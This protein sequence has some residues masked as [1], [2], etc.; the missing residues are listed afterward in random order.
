MRKEKAITNVAG[1]TFTA[2]DPNSRAA[3]IAPDVVSVNPQTG[4]I[5]FGVSAI[6][7]RSSKAY[8]HVRLFYA[9]DA[10]TGKPLVLARFVSDYINSADKGY[11]LKVHGDRKDGIKDVIY[12]AGFFKTLGLSEI[13]PFTAEMLTVPDKKND[14][15]FTFPD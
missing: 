13:K 15:L 10:N 8:N 6:N 3:G 1:V 14:V 9:K 7:R 5:R 11:K 4:Y 12:A 2:F